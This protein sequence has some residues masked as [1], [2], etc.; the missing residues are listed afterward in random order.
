MSCVMHSGRVQQLEPRARYTETSGWRI[1]CEVAVIYCSSFGDKIGSGVSVAVE[2][3]GDD[4]VVDQ[5][6]QR[7][8]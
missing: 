4:A 2:R 6:Q 3:I 1:G 8:P 7:I 5:L